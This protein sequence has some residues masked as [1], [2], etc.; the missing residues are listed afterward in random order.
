MNN[1]N[2]KD[3][4]RRII[5]IRSSRFGARGKS[6]FAAAIGI[7]PSTYSYYEQDRLPP[8]PIL[9]RIC[10]VAPCDINWLLTGQTA[11]TQGEAD[12]LAGPLAE[13]IK[14]LIS[15]N[16]KSASA[17]DAFV[18]LLAEK[19]SIEAGFEKNG[20]GGNIEKNTAALIPVLGRTAAGVLGLWENTATPNAKHLETHV[21]DLVEKYLNRPIIKSF[22]AQISADL[23]VKTVIEAASGEQV[24]LIQKSSADDGGIVEFVD[25][26]TVS[27]A[28][29]DC[30]ALQIDG[31]SMAPRIDDGDFVILSASR[32]AVQ[33]MPAVVRIVDSI[34]VTCKIIRING[35]DAHLIP[36]NERYET[37]I[38]P[39]SQ[40]LWSLAVLCHVKV[41][42]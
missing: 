39:S 29:N 40:L 26:P 31:D 41:K 28:F 23:Q 35:T 17:I 19:E 16:P 2:E 21:E 4:I 15:A 27:E 42:S 5:E 33:G 11:E 24:S 20:S 1:F 34:G 18:G 32:P 3:V 38:V 9:L 12:C 6:S 10:E 36:T 30:F 13:K 37:K 22:S 8:I 25:C 14:G 7:S